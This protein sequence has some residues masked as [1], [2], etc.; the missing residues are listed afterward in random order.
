MVLPICL[1]RSEKIV[2]PINISGMIKIQRKG[3]R[4]SLRM[5]IFKKNLEEVIPKVFDE[6][7]HRFR[8]G[9]ERMS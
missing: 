8:G 1:R 9:E 4:L 7:L 2:T 3:I 5:E 6:T